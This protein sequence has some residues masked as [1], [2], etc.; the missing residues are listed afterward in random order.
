MPSEA[1]LLKNNEG[2]VWKFSQSAMRAFPWLTED[3]LAAARIGLLKAI[4]THD[5]AKGAL[6]TA[7]A[8]NIRNEIEDL[9]ESEMLVRLPHT[10]KDRAKVVKRRR[11][12]GHKTAEIAA[13]LG[14]PAEKVRV[15]EL[16][17]H[18][19]ISLNIPI[20]ADESESEDAVAAV[21]DPAATPPEIVEAN[22]TAVIIASVIA[23]L[24]EKRRAAVTLR[25]WEDL[26]L[27]AIGD[28]L[29]NGKAGA[30]QLIKKAFSELRPTF[31]AR[32]LN[33][34]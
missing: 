21:P 12:A 26:T 32:G 28:K 15:A 34:F 14:I 8:F 19:H 7:A 20:H 31:A 30:D 29:E 22:N 16:D 25:F 4:R 9:I 11:E 13:S 27:E 23:N 10:A 33:A 24:S 2:L 3:I 6:S 5:P 18:P 17:G 1:D